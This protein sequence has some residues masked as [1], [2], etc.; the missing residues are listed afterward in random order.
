MKTVEK[1]NK[2]AGDYR[3]T[4]TANTKNYTFVIDGSLEPNNDITSVK[5]YVSN[6]KMALKKYLLT[7][8]AIGAAIKASNYVNRN[9][10]GNIPY[11]S[12]GICKK[13]VD[14]LEI[15]LINNVKCYLKADK[16]YLL[17]RQ[18]ISNY[19]N[20][21]L[22]RL[23]EESQNNFISLKNKALNEIN[24]KELY[25]SLDEKNK[26]LYSEINYDDA[27]SIILCNEGFQNYQKYLELS[28]K[29]FFTLVKEQG[30]KYCY[31]HLKRIEEKNFTLEKLPRFK[32]IDDIAA[33]YK[34]LV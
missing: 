11:I 25:S 33:I 21:L 12:L 30:V 8:N 6:L 27:H 23:K 3:L 34:I 2:K 10:K 19:K 4:A 31:S 13:N 28:N 9:F 20:T 24:F 16:V 32:K 22:K 17:E 7:E 14:K 26:Y 5:W 1:V 15:L 29:D 18:E